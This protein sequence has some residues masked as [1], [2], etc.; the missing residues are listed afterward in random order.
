MVPPDPAATV[1]APASQA[2]GDGLRH[3]AA[4]DIGTNSIHLLIAAVDP[5]LRSFRLVLAEKSTTRLGER[6]PETGDLTPEAIERA[7]IA[8]R[9][10]RQLAES[11]GVEQILTAATSAV[12]EAPNG[13]L[14]VQAVQ[15]QLDLE[16]DL[17]SGQEEARLIYLGV[18]S[19]MAFGDTPHLILDIGG[20]STELIL[21]DGSDARELTSTRIG[22]VRLQRD[23]IHEDP[24]PPARLTFLR[25]FIQGSLEPAVERVKRQLRPGEVPVMVGTSGTATALAA[26]VAAE[27][28]RTPLRLQGFRMS[29]E[30]IDQQVNRLTTLTPEQRRS[31]P[32]IN[33]RRAEIIVPGA[34]VLQQ[35]M[36]MLQTAEMVISE[37][38]L[39]EGLIVDWMLRHDLIVDRF[40]YQSGIR[41]RTVLQ[42]AQRYGVD[43]TRADRVAQHALSLYDRCR[44]VLHHD[45]GEGRQ[46]LWAAAMLHGSGQHINIGAY[47]KHSWYLIRHGDLLGYSETEQLMVAAIARYHR[48]SLPKKRHE[49]WLLLPGRE[50]RRAVNAM[51]M[52]L[53]LA[54]SLDRRPTPAVAGLR[55]SCST[56]ELSI[57]LEPASGL[58]LSLERW[59]LHAC[60]E[61]L[62][63]ATGVKLLVESDSR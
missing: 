17:V 3:V 37:R 11:H 5:H 44:G 56:S 41:R 51:A 19:G 59:S 40:A 6:D 22:A 34:L 15:E 33:E 31:L 54:A 55:I 2:A 30:Q 9:H 38:A 12:R 60:A 18:L 25:A 16:V 26:L 23:F 49:A 7:F 4:I 53:R 48:R 10:C 36:A 29:R 21:A 39:R 58:D 61:P 35:A 52:L 32:A 1:A 8:L 28:E 47:H 50:Q 62:A 14:F 24:M 13:R 20:G 57:G 46:L 43:Q 63:E 27:Q 45:E 42:L